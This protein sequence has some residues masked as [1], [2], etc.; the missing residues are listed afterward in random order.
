MLKQS[1]GKEGTDLLP[2]EGWGTFLSMESR[3]LLHLKEMSMQHCAHSEHDSCHSWGFQITFFLKNTPTLI[4]A[5]RDSSSCLQGACL[6]VRLA[7]PVA[8]MGKGVA[9]SSVFKMAQGSLPLSTSFPSVKL[10]EGLCCIPCQAVLYH[11]S[12]AWLGKREERLWW[13]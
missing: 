2:G 3:K 1:L 12:L 13:W 11:H 7:L 5:T 6:C 10:S 9:P 4:W 8:L